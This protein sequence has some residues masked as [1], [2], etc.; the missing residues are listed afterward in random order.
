MNVAK[1]IARINCPTLVAVVLCQFNDMPKGRLGRLEV[2]RLVLIPS[3]QKHSFHIG[4]IEPRRHCVI[5]PRALVISDRRNG[6][7]VAISGSGVLQILV[8][9]LRLVLGDRLQQRDGVS[10]FALLQQLQSLSVARIGRRPVGNGFDAGRQ[11]FARARRG[12]FGGTNGEQLVDD[13][14]NL[15]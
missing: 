1:P 3:I 7:E 10:G 12:C 13:R 14:L 2:A 5:F 9:A 15:E 4:G 6:R 11:V 8:G